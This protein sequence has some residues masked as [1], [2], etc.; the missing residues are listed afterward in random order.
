[1][2]KNSTVMQIARDSTRPQTDGVSDFSDG[3]EVEERGILDDTELESRVLRAVGDH[4]HGEPSTST[5]SS[6]VS[7]DNDPVYSAITSKLSAGCLCTNNCL[8]QFTTA[9]VFQFH[10][11]LYEMTK[12]AKD[13]LILGKLQVL[14]RTSDSIQHAR[15]TKAGKRKRVTCDYCFDHHHVCKDAFLFLHDIGS[16][17][18]KNLQKHLQENG[19]VPRDMV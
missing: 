6:L 5:N 1:M 17:I 13:M 2:T 14:S 11:S 12:V 4:D 16:K 19:P 9:E 3:E 15:Q 18:L 7:L 8:A 10:L